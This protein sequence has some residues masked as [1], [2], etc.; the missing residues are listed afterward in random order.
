M[1]KSN[2]TEAWHDAYTLF[3]EKF[4]MFQTLRAANLAYANVNPT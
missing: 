4:G 1:A 2:R 3:L